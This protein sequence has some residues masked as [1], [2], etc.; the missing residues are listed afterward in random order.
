MAAVDGMVSCWW[1]S[2]S[3][4]DQL[5]WPAY[6]QGR[7][8]RSLVALPSL[9]AAFSVTRRPSVRPSVCPSAPCLRFSGNR[10]AAKTSNL[11]QTWSRTGVTRRANLR[12][13]GQRSRSLGM[14]MWKLFSAHVF[15]K[16]GSVYVKPRPHCRIHV[17]LH[18]LGYTVSR[19]ADTIHVQWLYVRLLYPIV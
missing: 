15:V 1:S 2:G 19:L 5:T 17:T 10:K 9:G 18:L 6:Q 16:S 8:E 11:V 4:V 3:D 12:S 7:T 14:K 13:K